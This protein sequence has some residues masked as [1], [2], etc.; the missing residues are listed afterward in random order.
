MNFLS[1]YYLLPEKENIDLIIGNLLPDL[2]RGFTKIYN[3][4]IKSNSLTHDTK[5]VQGIHYHL[6]T[7]KLFHN[8]SFFQ[9]NC[10]VLKEITRFYR[11]PL[12]RNFIVS[13]IM[14]ELIIDQYL[15]EKSPSLAANFYKMLNAADLIKLEDQLKMTMPLQ[16]SSNIICIFK[17]FRE[18][19]YAYKLLEQ[20]GIQ[21]A[22]YHIVGKRIGLSFQE[23]DWKHAIQEGK[24]KI[25]EGLP[26][27]LKKI[28]H[29]LNDA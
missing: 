12:Q 26:F 5:F 27:F 21:A 10:N 24:E 3:L 8:A 9:K 4:E 1:H 13:H 23:Q 25:E 11:L 20:E 18:N 17:S 19:K 15:M 14:L 29:E 7:D 28:K 22:L 16:N 2:M 6:L